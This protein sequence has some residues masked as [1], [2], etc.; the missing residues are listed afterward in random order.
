MV[1]LLA[2]AFSVQRSVA[3]AESL[4]GLQSWQ[5]RN[6]FSGRV[7]FVRMLVGGI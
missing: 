5:V 6:A 4:I 2:F 1:G 3:A 7:K